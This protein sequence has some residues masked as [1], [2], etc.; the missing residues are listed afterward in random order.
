MKHH[1][2]DNFE[3]TSIHRYEIDHG[4]VRYVK[5][6]CE[7]VVCKDW[8]GFQRKAEEER[9]RARRE[10]IAEEQAAAYFG[11]RE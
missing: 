4:I 10:Y 11:R 8:D 1:I 9:Q 5:G 3:G 2:Q 6:D 7:Y